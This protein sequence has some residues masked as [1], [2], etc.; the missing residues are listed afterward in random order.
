MDLNHRIGD[1]QSPALITWL[2]RH[3]KCRALGVSLRAKLRPHVFR[4][5]SP[6]LIRFP[7]GSMKESIHVFIYITLQ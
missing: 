2:R 6:C 1:L 7:R 3:L 4:T 5:C